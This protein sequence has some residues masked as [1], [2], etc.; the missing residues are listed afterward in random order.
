MLVALMGV[1][2]LTGCSKEAQ[3][4]RVNYRQEGI[5]YMEQ[6]KYAEAVASFDEAL[7]QK[8][9]GV[10][11][12]DIDICFYKAAAQ[13]A[14][15]N[16]EGAIVTYQ[17]I[18]DFLPE[19]AEAFFHLGCIYI[20]NGELELAQTNFGQAIKN[21]A[22]NYELYLNIYENLAAA[23]Y[24]EEAEEYI[25]KA[26]LI[27][28]SEVTDNEYRGKMYYLLGEY[29]NAV[30]E[31]VAAKEKGSVI[32]D[33]YLGEVYAARGDAELAE[34]TYEIYLASNPADSVA[35]NAM[36]DLMLAE[37]RY[38]EAVSYLEQAYASEVLTNRQEV[39]RNLV[40]AYEY[41][42]NFDKAWDMIQAYVELYPE[43]AKA[44]TEYI[45]LENRQEKEAPAEGTN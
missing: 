28:G 35:L 8:I 38:G 23:D 36:G 33:L 42:G 4:S 6:G 19:E 44:Q 17:A 10:D 13:Y 14:G 5:T 39:M 20:K 27:K 26:F 1:C 22:S 34:S 25:Q 32:A 2:F 18:A 15:G 37:E 3:E 31:L 29:D 41:N 43:D 45:F 7:T 12:D 24:V 11:A 9:G 30:T 16:V 40:E 21:E